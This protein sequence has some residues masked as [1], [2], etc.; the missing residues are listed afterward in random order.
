MSG[1]RRTFAD[2]YGSWAVVAGASEG[3]GAAFA[4]ELARRGLHVVLVARRQA[5]LD[6]LADRLRSEWD[7]DTLTLALDLADPDSVDALERGVGDRE[8]GLV[9]MNAAYVP[10][11]PFGQVAEEDLAQA[12]SVNCST[13]VRLTRRLL[14][15][16]VERGRGGCVVVSSLAGLQGS[17]MLATYAATKAFG[18]TLAEGL[19]HEFAPQGVHVVGCAAGA[20]GAPKLQAVKQRRAPGTMSP[21]TVARITIDSLG[22]GPRVVPGLINRIAATVMGRCL[23][24][25]LAVRLM[26]RNTADLR[27]ADP[28]A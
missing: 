15:P 1:G 2:R 4:T 23:P 10:I 3:L 6:A 14:P 17:P 25:A 11:G 27:T 9:V 13:T 21:E 7:V 20:I 22:R 19:W 5:P 8:I 28:P 24:R 26:A 18:L 16:M 12:V